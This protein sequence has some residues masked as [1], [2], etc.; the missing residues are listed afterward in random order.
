MVS[1]S[2]ILLPVETAVQGIAEVQAEMLDLARTFAHDTGEATP[3]RLKA[4]EVTAKL[5]TSMLMTLKMQE[6]MRIVALEAAREA[7]RPIPAHLRRRTD[8]FEPL[9]R[10]RAARVLQS[11]AAALGTDQPTTVDVANAKTPDW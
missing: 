5:A 1:K 9:D 6:D 11:E 10:A 4:I 3:V 7:L 8:L 2:E